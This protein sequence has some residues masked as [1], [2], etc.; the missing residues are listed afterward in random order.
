MKQMLL[1]VTAMLLVAGV[2]VAD[3]I[4][5]YSDATGTNCVLAPGF[6]TSATVVHKFSAGATGSRFDL[7]FPAGTSFFSFGSAFPC[8]S[9][10]VW[11]PDGISIGYCECLAGSIVIGTITAILAPGTIRVVPATGFATVMAAD[12]GFVEHPATGGVAYVGTPGPCMVPTD[13]T[14]WGKVK[15]LYR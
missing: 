8:I 1:L 9:V 4:G 3:H 10:P 14:T 11:N 2:A 15:S 12:C 13:Q 5:I 6:S 7:E